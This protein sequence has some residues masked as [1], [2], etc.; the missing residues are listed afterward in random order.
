MAEQTT[1]I[2]KC[3]DC[4]NEMKWADKRH[5][6]FTGKPEQIIQCIQCR[7]WKFLD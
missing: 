2:N 6:P 1:E 3:P 4:G 5:N 7:R